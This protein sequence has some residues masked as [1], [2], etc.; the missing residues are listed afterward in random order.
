MTPRAAA[1]SIRLTA[2]RRSASTLSSPRSAD[3]VAVL[4]R[5]LI[6]DFTALLRSRRTSLVRLRLIWLLMLA[7]AVLGQRCSGN[8]NRL[9]ASGR[10]VGRTARQD[11]TVHCPRPGAPD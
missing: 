11:G 7:T 3:R 4:A 5:V 1:L 9:A 6:S 8:R 10:P 2:T